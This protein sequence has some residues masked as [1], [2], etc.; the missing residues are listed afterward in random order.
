MEREKEGYNGENQRRASIVLF[1]VHAPVPTLFVILVT[2]RPQHPAFVSTPPR[3]INSPHPPNGRR[4]FDFSEKAGLA[5]DFAERVNGF[6]EA[7]GPEYNRYPPSLAPHCPLFV[8]RSFF[9]LSA[10]FLKKKNKKVCLF[11]QSACKI[12]RQYTR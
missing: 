8:P 2:R 12:V 9:F 1:R 5:P 11:Q 7:A 3:H 10:Y 4:K 6:R